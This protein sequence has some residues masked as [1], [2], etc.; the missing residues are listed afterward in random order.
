MAK[1]QGG[2]SSTMQSAAPMKNEA[3]PGSVMDRNVCPYFD[4]PRDKSPSDKAEVFFTG[5][6]GSTHHGKVDGADISSTMHGPQSSSTGKR[7][8]EL[9]RESD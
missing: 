4:K 7:E 5:V 1:N 2:L 3:A 6:R 9:G 8:S